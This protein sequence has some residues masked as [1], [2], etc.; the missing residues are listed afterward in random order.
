M[1]KMKGK[2]MK[3]VLMIVPCFPPIGGSA[4]QRTLKFVKYLPTFGWNPI[5]LTI[6]E[7]DKSEE[8]VDTSLLNEIPETLKIYRS[9]YFGFSLMFRFLNT[10]RKQ[11]S[12]NI[13]SCASSHN[14][15]VNK[16]RDIIRPFIIPDP[17]VGWYPFAISKCKQIFKENNIDLIYSSSPYP[18]ANLVAMS[19][20]KKYKKPWVADFR[21][22]WTEPFYFKRPFPLKQWEKSLERSVL[23]RADK[24]VVAWPAIQDGF[25]SQYKLHRQKIILIHNGFDEQDF[26]DIVPKAFEKFTIIHTGTFYKQRNPEALFKAMLSLLSKKPRLRNDIQVIL[27]GW[28]WENPSNLIEENNLNDIVLTVPYLPHEEC[29]RYLLGADVLFLNTIQNYVPGKVFEY[30]RGKKPILALVPKD[31][32]VAEIVSS[33][34]S[35]V[36]INPTNTE[37]IKDAILEM[38]EKYKE[39]TLKLDREDDSV[40]Y[41]YERK[42]LTRKL[43]EVLDEVSLKKL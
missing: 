43:A 36:V 2:R 8:I 3:N 40:I 10:K 20:A 5:I 37:E 1:E 38:Y 41:Q 31:T 35:G 17:R 32:T 15:S 13:V 21:D 27:L 9:G 19:V 30:L 33:T 23:R 39:G 22:P 24:I 28:C 11:K 7:G 29:L 42:E 26:Q 34:K 12:K 16:I 25:M 4:I 18:I 14:N 6:D